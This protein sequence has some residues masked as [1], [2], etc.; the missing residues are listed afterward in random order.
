MTRAHVQRMA[1][2]SPWAGEGKYAAANLDQHISRPWAQAH[3]LLRPTCDC[4][5]S[6]HV[7]RLSWQVDHSTGE[8]LLLVEHCFANC[9]GIFNRSGWS[10]YA[11]K[12]R[13]KRTEVF[14]FFANGHCSPR[15]DY[16]VRGIVSQFAICLNHQF[17]RKTCWIHSLQDARLFI[18]ISCTEAKSDVVGLIASLVIQI[19]LSMTDQWQM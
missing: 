6:V 12:N 19:N 2:K 4:F 16:T 13:L 18:L 10:L 1:W 11:N 9:S 5:F 7:F 15:R 3:E 14:R 17:M 8:I